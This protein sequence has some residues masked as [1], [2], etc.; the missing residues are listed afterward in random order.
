MFCLKPPVAFPSESFQNGKK[1]QKP[2][3]LFK[4]KYLW[5]WLNPS[6]SFP[7]LTILAKLE[8]WSCCPAKHKSPEIQRSLK[9][10]YPEKNFNPYWGSEEAR[11]SVSS[12]LFKGL[13]PGFSFSFCGRARILPPQH[14]TVSSIWWRRVG[15]QIS[16]FHSWPWW[17]RD[18]PISNGNK[19]SVNFNRLCKVRNSDETLDKLLANVRHFLLIW[20]ETR[21]K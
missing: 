6:D 13:L 19:L 16:G 10:A 11:T 1:N 4:R 9:G 21:R 2:L 15:T 18:G 14:R 8:R 12:F 7:L 17:L 20:E 5:L 3:W